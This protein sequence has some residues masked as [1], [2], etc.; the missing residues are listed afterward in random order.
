MSDERKE[1]QKK[2]IKTSE[3]KNWIEYKMAKAEEEQER[4]EKRVINF[5]SSLNRKPNIKYV[6]NKMK[7]F[8]EKF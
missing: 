8:K 7:V 4:K 3:I 1:K 5:A 2:W 6:W